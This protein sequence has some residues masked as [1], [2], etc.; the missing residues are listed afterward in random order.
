MYQHSAAVSMKLS[1]QEEPEEID[2]FSEE[3]EDALYRVCGA[4]LHRMITV[5]GEKASS[6]KQA[7]RE[8]DFLKQISMTND[9]KLYSL[10]LSLLSTEQGGRIFSKP[11]LLPFIQL[12][13]SKVKEEVNDAAFKQ[14]GENLFKVCIVKTNW[15]NDFNNYFM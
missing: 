7:R 1:A 12:V 11:E 9:D 14:F 3:S 4:Q 5:R 15:H 8:L 6:N 10:P 13:V 2:L